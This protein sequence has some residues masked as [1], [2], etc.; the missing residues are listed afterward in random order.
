MGKK[1]TEPQ[2]IK[3]LG[4]QDLF[5]YEED[6]SLE[7]LQEYIIVPFVKVIQGMSEQD[8]KDTF[9]EG[10][11]ILRPGDVKI[12]DR[13]T[14]FLFVPIFFYTMFRKWADRTDTQMILDT[15]YDPN[16]DLAK[17]SRDPD[18]REEI[19]EGDEGKT[20]PRKYRYVEHL[21]FIGVVYDGEMSGTRCL[22]S[23]QKG[24]FRVGRG[25]ASGAQMRKIKD[26]DGTKKQ[27]PLWAQVWLMKLNLR[28]R[29]DNRWWGLD[30]TS[31]PE[32]VESM[33]S[34]DEFED[35]HEAYE[36]LAKAHKNNLIRI[37]GDEADPDEGSA[38]DDF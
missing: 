12:G 33:I 21:C 8:L 11:A 37:E 22:I 3:V 32:G 14:P 4:V 19:Y 29:N 28:E 7:A 5:K 26:A 6:K 1:R 18:R 34:P 35:F 10:S 13:K 15:S 2:A 9:G 20:E 24:D 31:P 25:F 23:F 30:P 38:T 17:L 16:C 27:V 36:E